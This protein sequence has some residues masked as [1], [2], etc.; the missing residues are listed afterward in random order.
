MWGSKTEVGDNVGECAVCQGFQMLD[1]QYLRFDI[2][3]AVLFDL[4]AE[5][6]QHAGSEIRGLD[7]GQGGLGFD[8][9]GDDA[10]PTRIV[11]DVRFIGDWK[12]FGEGRQEDSRN[13]QGG[14][15]GHLIV[16]VGMCVVEAMG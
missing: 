14:T 7:F 8:E 15:A 10:S 13:V 3:P 2:D 6:L 4:G 12:S 5:N 11:E 1:I 9:R 16:G